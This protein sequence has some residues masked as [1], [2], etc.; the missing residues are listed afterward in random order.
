MTKEE[1]YEMK[2]LLSWDDALTLISN[3]QSNN[4]PI[5]EADR[6][7]IH[8]AHFI[9]PKLAFDSLI[10]NHADANRIHFMLGYHETTASSSRVGLTLAILGLTYNPTSDSPYY[11]TLKVADGDFVYDPLGSGDGSNSNLSI[12]QLD[13][14]VNKYRD[15]Y[16]IPIASG[17]KTNLK[18]FHF[19]TSELND[20]KNQPGV[21][22]IE[23]LLG[24]HTTTSSSKNDQIGYT[25]ILVALDHDGNRL[26]NVE[27]GHLIYD[28]CD[29][30]PR[31]CPNNI[32]FFE[33]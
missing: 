18:G 13:G 5:P 32:D 15:Q 11:G 9:F 21:A 31:K 1:L 19:P 22:S 24:Y 6:S 29:P 10:S 7:P 16:A 3:Y 25:L 4:R 2:A 12:S 20:L 28:Y 27:D 8:L 17:I 26:N 33:K 14:I 30:C 23:C